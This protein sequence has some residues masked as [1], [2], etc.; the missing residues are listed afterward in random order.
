ME[1]D[2][3]QVPATNAG[4]VPS[5]RRDGQVPSTKDEGQV[6]A[7][8]PAKAPKTRTSSEPAEKPDK[9]RREV[10]SYDGQRLGVQL[11]DGRISELAGPRQIYLATT[12]AGDG[13]LRIV[14]ETPFTRFPV[15]VIDD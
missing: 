3:G 10:R 15:V 5:T 2:T 14:D 6:P 11:P 13:P 8:K 1:S 12:T 4:Q 9:V 7:T